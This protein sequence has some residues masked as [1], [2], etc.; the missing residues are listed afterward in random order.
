MKGRKPK[1][2]EQKIAEGNPSQHKLPEPVLIRGRGMEKPEAMTP[3]ENEV[4]DEVVPQLVQANFVDGADVTML[5]AL[6]TNIAR[7]REAR[8]IIQREGMI[9]YTRGGMPCVHPA[10]RVER[11]AW[12][13]ALRIGEQFG[14]TPSARTRLG[15]QALKGRTLEQDLLDRLGD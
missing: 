10:I 15:Y 13:S 6:C 1:P 5:E 8:E 9:A 12:A 4:W 3:R 7:A 2:L 11:D 14:L